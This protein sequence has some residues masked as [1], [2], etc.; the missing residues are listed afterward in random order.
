M[1]ELDLFGSVDRRGSSGAR[2]NVSDIADADAKFHPFARRPAGQVSSQYMRKTCSNQTLPSSV[3]DGDSGLEMRSHTALRNISASSSSSKRIPN[4]LVC[5]RFT[6]Q[7]PQ[8]DEGGTN[9]AVKPV[10]A[11]QPVDMV[12]EPALCRE[13]VR[14]EDLPR[15]SFVA[16]EEP[17]RELV[18]VLGAEDEDASVAVVL[19][20]GRGGVGV[21]DLGQ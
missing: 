8:Y 7:L 1:R 14:P 3:L 21:V 15:A 10:K 4:F 17:E 19:P 18:V 6:G 16:G 2:L 20:F 13:P 5:D 9:Q 12:V 11:R